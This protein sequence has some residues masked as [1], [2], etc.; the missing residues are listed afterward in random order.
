MER[1]TVSLHARGAALHDIGKLLVKGVR[2][3]DVPHEPLLEEGERTDT[4]GPVDDLVRDNKVHGLDV[5]PEGP[6]GGESDDAPDAN[7][8]QG[9]DVGA[10]GDLVGRELVVDAVAGE[11]SYGYAIVPRDE[12]RRRGEAPGCRGV[13]RGHRLEAGD[14]AE[15]GPAD[16]GDVDGFCGRVLDRML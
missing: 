1:N 8:A 9:G 12:D 15:A 16:D 5:L 14:A 2:K 3:G 11:E 4:L 6:D 7:G 13:D 10:G